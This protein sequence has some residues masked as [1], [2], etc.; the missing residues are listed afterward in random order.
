MKI[1]SNPNDTV[2]TKYAFYRTEEILGLT[3]EYEQLDSPFGIRHAHIFTFGGV[4]LNDSSL[5]KSLLSPDP[6][7]QKS[8]GLIFA[9]LLNV[10]EGASD[11]LKEWIITKLVSVTEDA[12]EI[13]IPALTV[14]TRNNTARKVAL[15]D[16]GVV[17]N[18]AS[19]FKTLDFK[20]KTQQLYELCFILWSLSLGDVNHAA[21][22]SSGVIPALVD[23]L[24]LSPTRKVVRMTL[25]TL[26][27]I[28]ATED[29]SILNEMYTTWLPKALD[30]MQN[31]H[32]LRTANDEEAEGD[33]KF[34]CEVLS[35]NFRELSSYERWASQVHSGALR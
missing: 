34:L 6:E 28:S 3:G 13:A 35:R 11:R 14:F 19:I 17:Q 16:A 27:N 23:I 22:L 20:G 15:A 4:Y 7:V 26:R 32:F 2:V 33:F 21:Y 31:N 10:Y 24:T 30:A 18:I 12:W 29:D 9:T 1:A 25:G 5:V 8:A